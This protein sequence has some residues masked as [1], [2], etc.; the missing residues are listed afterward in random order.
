MTRLVSKIYG[1]GEPARDHVGAVARIWR[2]SRDLWRDHGTVI[3]KPRD[4]PPDLGA[5][6]REWAEDQ[7]GRGRHG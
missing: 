6:L 3:V 2:L 4:L 7:Y 1:M 5:R